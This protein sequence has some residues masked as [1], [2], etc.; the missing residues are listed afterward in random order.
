M[1]FSKSYSDQSIKDAAKWLRYLED[2]RST[3]LNIYEAKYHSE[4][5]KYSKL[6]HLGVFNAEKREA[7][8][9]LE[10]FGNGSMMMVLN[11][12]F[13]GDNKDFEKF[14]KESIILAFNYGFG[15]NQ[16]KSMYKKFSKNKMK[17]SDFH[18]SGEDW[19]KDF[20]IPEVIKENLSIEEVEEKFS[21]DEYEDIENEDDEDYEDD[22]E[23]DNKEEDEEEYDYEKEKF[24]KIKSLLGNI[25]NNDDKRFKFY[26]DL[27]EL[28]KNDN[29]KIF[30]EK[31]WKFLSSV[32]F[33]VDITSEE[34][35]KKL[36]S[37]SPELLKI[38]KSQNYRVYF[39][40]L[41]PELV[42]NLFKSQGFPV[43]ITSFVPT[44]EGFSNESKSYPAYKDFSFFKLRDY[45]EINKV[46]EK[47]Y[48]SYVSYYP[49]SFSKL[50]LKY[51]K[52]GRLILSSNLFFSSQVSMNI[53]NK[54]VE[55]INIEN[56]MSPL[57][58]LKA[59]DTYEVKNPKYNYLKVQDIISINHQTE[60]KY[61]SNFTLFSV[62]EVIDKNSLGYF[63]YK[64]FLETFNN[65][66]KNL[67]FEEHQK[68][69]DEIEL[70]LPKGLVNLSDLFN[71]NNSR[72]KED[73]Y[74]ENGS[75]YDD[76]DLEVL[77]KLNDLNFNLDINNLKKK[78]GI[79][80]KSVELA[81]IIERL[82]A[83]YI[84]DYKFYKKYNDLYED[85]EDYNSFDLAYNCKIK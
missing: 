64:N 61:K 17:L 49:F 85:I 9:T 53:S 27:F 78:F 18:I 16:G 4:I 58:L 30:E 8:K 37:F 48:D 82:I 70:I 12:F 84:N 10:S 39:D 5:T 71:L 45:L 83:P 28:E 33:D 20:F 3:L 72:Q 59:D 81:L 62:D 1:F 23:D 43:K 25:K 11:Y 35:D 56:N 24:N 75:Y 2:N 34:L 42:F 14:S 15:L 19:V 36:N 51:P 55:I 60:N 67:D 38:Y 63:Q 52:Y 26:Q 29:P 77:E 47:F 40:F 22:D 69:L 74:E 44:D 66:S 32:N 68:K 13:D 73:F 7:F 21:N 76:F 31:N 50:G 41:I 6:T 65:L 57:E 54:N 79:L 80:P 46:E